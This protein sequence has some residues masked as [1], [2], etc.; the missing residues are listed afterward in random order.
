MN[1]N[2]FSKVPVL[3]ICHILIRLSGVLIGWAGSSVTLSGFKTFVG[4]LDAV[5]VTKDVLAPT[6]QMLPSISM[7]TEDAISFATPPRRRFQSG[8]PCAVYVAINPSLNPPS[9]PFIHAEL[10]DSVVPTKTILT[11]VKARS[12][13]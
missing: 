5:G 8:A 7:A 2:V 13:I 9:G 12:L 11:G 6:T 3:L 4:V 1:S 10:A